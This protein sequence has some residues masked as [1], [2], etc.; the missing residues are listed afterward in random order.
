[1]I[2]VATTALGLL[3]IRFL[4]DRRWFDAFDPRSWSFGDL[5]MY[6]FS[7]H[8]APVLECWTLAVIGLSMRRPRPSRE[9]V[10]ASPGFVACLA[11]VAGLAC[12]FLMFAVEA[13]RV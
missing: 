4:E 2:L 8:T 7:L 11:A 9:C 13:A 3:P 5:L 1:M 12:Q 6:K 10:A